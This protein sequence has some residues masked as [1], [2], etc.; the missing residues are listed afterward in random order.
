MRRTKVFVIDLTERIKDELD[1]NDKKGFCHKICYQTQKGILP[2]R[3]RWLDKV[4]EEGIPIY[5]PL[6]SKLHDGKRL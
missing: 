3:K 6:G 4:P 2:D 5:E 1:R